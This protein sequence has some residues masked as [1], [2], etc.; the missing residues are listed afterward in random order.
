MRNTSTC[1]VLRQANKSHDTRICHTYILKY[2]GVQF[3]VPVPACPRALT[4]QT[5]LAA[6]LSL[7]LQLQLIPLPCPLYSSPV[8]HSLYSLPGENQNVVV[9][10]FVQAAP[11]AAAFPPSLSPSLFSPLSP[12]VDFPFPFWLLLLLRAMKLIYFCFASNAVKKIQKIK[13]KKNTKNFYSS[14]HY[15]WLRSCLGLARG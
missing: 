14:Y 10:D 15:A 2:A 12:L 3:R 8:H 11:L 6:P 1:R 7:H 5:V 4:L 13:A 9:M